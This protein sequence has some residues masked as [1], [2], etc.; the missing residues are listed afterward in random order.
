MPR[1]PPVT[2]ALRAVRLWSAVLIQF[3]GFL[4]HAQC[5]SQ[6]TSHFVS[7]YL[8]EFFT[9]PSKGGRR[10][11]KVTTN[12]GPG[13]RN[14]P[15][16]L[17]LNQCLPFNL[18]SKIIKY[19]IDK[20]PV[21]RCTERFLISLNGE[22]NPPQI[23]WNTSHLPD[24]LAGGGR[25]AERWASSIT[26]LLL[27]YTVFFFQFGKRARYKSCRLISCMPRCN[28]SMVT[29][30]ILLDQVI[31]K[32]RYSTITKLSKQNWKN[33][34]S[35]AVKLCFRCN[36]QTGRCASLSHAQQWQLC[37]VVAS[38]SPLWIVTESGLISRTCFSPQYQS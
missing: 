29:A 16:N 30:S 23:R 10:L 22:S 38:L 32:M 34:Q 12:A 21:N 15:F 9:R 17:N 7:G 3:W 5:S 24:C 1:R 14:A 37:A 31:N 13:L 28:L 35:D 33:L 11:Y 8:W 6:L 25:V 18:N 4:Y 26:I 19:E 2:H 27:T 36:R 20:D